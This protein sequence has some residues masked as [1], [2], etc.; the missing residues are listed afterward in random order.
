MPIMTIPPVPQSPQRSSAPG[1]M[2]SFTFFSIVFLLMLPIR[3]SRIMPSLSMKK[4]GGV[5]AMR[6]RAAISGGWAAAV[7]RPRPRRPADPAGPV[8]EP[9][10][11]DDDRS[12]CDSGED[13]PEGAGPGAGER[14]AEDDLLGHVLFL[15]R[16]LRPRRRAPAP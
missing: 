10:E 16:H 9:D 2:I 5:P 15:G 4:W 14:A 3:H 7:G 12:H 8:E 6:W 11:G 13:V 1:P